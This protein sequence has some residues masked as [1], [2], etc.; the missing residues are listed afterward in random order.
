MTCFHGQLGKEMGAKEGLGIRI[1]GFHVVEKAGRL[2]I[3]ETQRGQKLH[4]LRSL[5]FAKGIDESNLQCIIFAISGWGQD[6]SLNFSCY[7]VV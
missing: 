3:T 6:D 4:V 5:S 2:S 7:D 1:E